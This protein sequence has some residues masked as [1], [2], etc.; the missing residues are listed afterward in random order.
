MSVMAGIRVVVVWSGL[1]VAIVS[2]SVTVSAATN[3]ND[4]GNA[5]RGRELASACAACH[6]PDGNSPSPAFPIIA[7]Q[8]QEYLYSALKAYQ[9][10]GRDNAIMSATIVGLNDQ[11]LQDLAAWFSSQKGLGAGQ[12][13]GE[14]V[15][16]QQG[17]QPGG[18]VA[19][20]ATASG[21]LLAEGGSELDIA[22]SDTQATGLPDASL[23][24]DGES[25]TKDSDHDGLADAYDAAP[26]DANEFVLDTNGDD[27][28]EICNI[29]QLQ[30]ILTLGMADRTATGLGQ[31]VRMARDYELVHNIDAAAITN[32]QPIGNCGPTGNCMNDLDKYGFKGSFD[33]RGHVISNLVINAPDVGGVGLFGVISS[34]KVVR[35]IELRN[36]K[37]SGR[38]GTGTIVGSNFGTVYNC[39]SVGGEVTGMYA[40]GGLVGANAGNISYS[41]AEVN[42]KGQMAA[43]GLVGD[44]NANVFSSYATG[45]VVADRG[46]GGLVGLNTRG[47]VISSYATGTVSGGKDVGGLVGLNTDALLVNS[48]A[49]GMVTGTEMNAGALVGF[50]SMSR[51][52]NA[53]ATGSV[54]GSA[55]A[56]GIAGNNNGVIF[57]S[58]ANGRV[59]GKSDTGGL[60]GKNADGIVEASYWNI[61]ST[62]QKKA[63]G[64]IEGDFSDTTRVN[65]NGLKQ[66]N[67]DVTGW[68]A[69]DLSVARS[70]P[71]LWF[72]DIDGSGEVETSEQIASNYAWHMGTESELPVL[73]CPPGGIDRQRR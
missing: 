71:E 54:N 51:I 18:G 41:H 63:S 45:K 22:E 36:A 67:G 72:C 40:I 49:T 34:G 3:G 25:V 20:A 4:V 61:D 7:G 23:C 35:N 21:A 42:V 2:A 27:R 37:V 56:G 58:Y 47:R 59:S 39:H 44:Q 29:Q 19:A 16:Q 38:A 43:G 30:A 50:N 10:R 8:H 62:G 13:Q 11:Q 48:Y 5:D 17:E 69:A 68:A 32:W 9:D 6:G 57:Q 31:S 14:Q 46:A 55:A 26:N 53:Y 15:L 60:V 65:E 73:S 28:Y 64:T 24:P 12:D 33:G 52:R 66:L 1:M 70:E